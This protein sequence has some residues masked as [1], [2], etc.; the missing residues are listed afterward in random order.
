MDLARALA[1][2][3]GKEAVLL[4]PAEETLAAGN[5]GLLK[6]ALENLVVNGVRY[7][8]ERIVLRLETG[9]DRVKICV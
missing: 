4:S 6:I 3:N 8:K 7:A 1:A 5:E 9:N 2:Q